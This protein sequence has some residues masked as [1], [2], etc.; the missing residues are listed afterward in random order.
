LKIVADR[1]VA[2]VRESD[3]LSRLSAD[4]FA[5]LIPNV[6]DPPVI[7][8]LATRLLTILGQPFDL[9]E[10]RVRLSA[11]I[12]VAVYPEHGDTES[13]LLRSAEAAVGTAKARGGNQWVLSNG[14]FVPSRQ[15]LSLETRLHAAIEEG[16]IH[17]HYQPIVS[18]LGELRG[19]EALMRWTS[20]EGE[21][22]PPS[23]FIPAAEACG[24][25]HLLGGW[26]L[27]L[28]CSQ[29]ARWG[30]SDLYVSVNVSPKQF[31]R[32]GFELTVKTAL[33]AADLD[34]SRLMLEITEGVLMLDPGYARSLLT[35]LRQMG[36]QVAVDDFGTGHSSLAYLK[37]LPVT[38]LKVDQSF[39]KGLPEDGKDRAIVSSVL[40]LAKDLGLSSVVEGVERQTQAETVKRLGCT[41]M[42]GWLFGGPRA[43]DSFAA[44]FLEQ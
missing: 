42:Q 41:Y 2:G 40:T 44:N 15:S 38:T 36:V 12:G 37:T 34:P 8:D 30:R 5:L 23:E 11:S 43:P 20:A 14:S 28:A 18:A 3:G 39:V 26:S 29:L 25:I 22:T 10:E 17:L 31:L 32:E 21:S 27:R 35:K 13:L 6:S 1:L 4:E 24:L 9:T 19:C 16:E 33:A 7:A